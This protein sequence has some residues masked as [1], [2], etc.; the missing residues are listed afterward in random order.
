MLAPLAFFLLTMLTACAPSLT[1][2]C[3]LDGRRVEIEAGRDRPVILEF[4]A[5][6]R[7]KKSRPRLSASSL[8]ERGRTRYGPAGR[9]DT[10]HETS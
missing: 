3:V 2:C 5:H 6:P 10:K 4:P 7:G 8:S 9:Q 1:I